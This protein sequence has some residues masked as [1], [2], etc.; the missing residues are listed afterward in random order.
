MPAGIEEVKEAKEEGVKFMNLHNPI[1]YLTDDNGKV[2]QA[3]LQVMELGEP[4]ESG[5]RSPVPVEGKTVTIDADEVIVAVG[6]IPNNVVSRAIPGLELG[7]KDVIIVN[8]N[9]QSN[10]SD[11]YAGGDITRG[12]A[13]VVLAMRDGKLAAKNMI[14]QLQK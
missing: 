13:T 6:V 11:V 1:K 7:R 4:D 2:K 12:G 3:V 5:R 14:A 8:E 10:L 9:Q